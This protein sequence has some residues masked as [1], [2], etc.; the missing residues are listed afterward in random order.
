M[1]NFEDKVTSKLACDACGE[2]AIQMIMN[3]MNL[4]VLSIVA[5]MAPFKVKVKN[6]VLTYVSN[7]L[8]IEN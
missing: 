2:H 3:S 8:Q 6:I 4:L 1:K 7:V 5:V